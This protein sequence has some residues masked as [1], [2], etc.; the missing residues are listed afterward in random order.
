VFA[1]DPAMLVSWGTEIECVSA[2]SRRERQ[3]SVIANVVVEAL[4][5]LSSLVAAWHEIEPTDRLRRTARRLLRVHD[6]R[7]ADALQLAAALVAAEDQPASLEFASLDVR[8]IEAA[9][10]E[11]FPVLDLEAPKVRGA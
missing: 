7:G 3:G 9:R 10:R 4:D 1:A 8:L 11:G 2:L 5:D 6:L